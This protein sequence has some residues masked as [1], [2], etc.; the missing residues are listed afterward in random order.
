MHKEAEAWPRALEQVDDLLVRS[1][2]EIASIDGEEMVTN[3]K[4]TVGRAAVDNFGHGGWH[5]K[6][7]PAC[8]GKAIAV[9]TL[10]DVNDNCVTAT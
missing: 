3:T 6:A 9:T 7:L 10:L 5:A 1:V 8:H 2:G 4:A